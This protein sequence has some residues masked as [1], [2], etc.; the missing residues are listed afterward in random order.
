MAVPLA[1][2]ILILIQQLIQI[3][4]PVKGQLH[5]PLKEILRRQMKR[6]HHLIKHL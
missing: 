2:D 3:Q 1:V 5:I 6:I 4:G